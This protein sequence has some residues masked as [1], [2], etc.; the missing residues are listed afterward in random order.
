MKGLRVAVRIG[1]LA[2]AV[3]VAAASGAV[4]AER[5]PN[6][7]SALNEVE[8]KRPLA[9]ARSN[10]SVQIGGTTRH[11]LSSTSATRFRVNSIQ[12][13]G[14]TAFSDLELL[15]LVEDVAGHDVTLAD[16]EAAAERI[17]Q[18]YRANGYPVARA[19]IPAQRVERG[20]V[21]IAVLEGH[22]GKLDV[23]NNSRLSDSFVRDTLR[24]AASDAVI[25]TS[26]LDRDVLLLKDL[27]GVAVTATLAPGDAVG[28]SDLVVDIGAAPMFSG[29]LET[30]N[31][32]N[33]Y[34]GELRYGG[35]AAV[36][37]LAGRGDLLTVRG[38][39][40]ENSGLWYG[41]AAYLVPVTSGG[42][43]AGGAVSHTYYSLGD[44][45]SSLDADGE[46][47]IYS[48]L[49]QYP[50]LRSI[51]ANIDVQTAFNYFDLN[52]KI[53]A[54]SSSD[55]RSL[56]SMT[57]SVSGNL[58]DGLLGGGMNAASLTIAGGSL[59]LDDALAA[60]IDRATAR[61]E[62][63]FGIAGYSLMRLQRITD[64]LQL[65]VA[66][67]GQYSNKNLDASQK[68]VLGGPNAVRAYDQGVGIGDQGLLGT[69][70]LRCELPSTGWFTHPTAFAFFDGGTID[71]NHDP[72]LSAENR[73]DLYGAGI[74]I[75]LDTAF[76][77][78]VRG[79]VAWPVGSQSG[80]ES[81][82]TRSWLQVVKA[83]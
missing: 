5:P 36:A 17:T 69:V 20:G 2:V 81:S 13:S 27:A 15:P 42:L 72:F 73:V 7:G 54:A 50:V 12:I 26:A 74:G 52:D 76:G 58:S 78:T 62:G 79:S 6:I 75:H 77:F 82:G 32:G 11:A 65:Y 16:L 28:T 48:L 80:L 31:F 47:N 22:Y 10:P 56:Q 61:T 1:T 14:T 59:H 30:D 57:L 46:A 71:V 64:P 41:R 67:Q 24:A 8:Q 21:E 19:Y 39:I 43:R 45:F 4:A 60:T 34:T 44:K 33:Q 40:S 66:I 51:R 18:F 83:L 68:F 9:P 29:T 53:G 37:N 35:S 23:R 38:L 70:E 3:A 63:T 55:P 49:T 25:E